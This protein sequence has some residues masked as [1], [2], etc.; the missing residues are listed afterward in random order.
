M[1]DN[2]TIALYGLILLLIIQVCLGGTII[3]VMRRRRGFD[4]PWSWATCNGKYAVLTLAIGFV[5]VFPG[6]FGKFL[7]A[8]VS[9]TGLKYYADLSFWYAFLAMLGVFFVLLA[10]AALL[11]AA[12]QVD[13]FRAWSLFEP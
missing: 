12:L 5:S 9:Y 8:L 7:V 13:L 1:R 10:S 2:P 3:Y 6:A 11:S 4:P